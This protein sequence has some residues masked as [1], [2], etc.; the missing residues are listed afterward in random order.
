MP[1]SSPLSVKT[2]QEAIQKFSDEQTC[3]D[4]VAA[5][6]WPDG[7]T[8]PACGHKE[9]WYLKTQ[10]RWKCK[11]CHRQF[12]VKLGTIFED[13]PIGLDKWL[14][15]M[16]MI[17]NCKNGVSSYEIHRAIGVTQK[18]A[19]FM[20]HRLRLVM[21]QNNGC[22]KLGGGLK[23]VE[24]DETF[25]GGKARNMHKDV[26]ARRIHAK[27]GNSAVDKVLVMGM[28]ERGG[29]VRTE[30]IHNRFTDTLRQNVNKHVVSGSLLYT[31]ELQAYK[32]L[33]DEYSHMFV[34]HSES[35]VQGRVSTNGVENFWSLL[36]R[37]LGGT[38]V[39]VEPFHMFRYLDEQTWRYNNRGNKENPVNDGQRF[40]MALAQVT[41]KRLT[42]SALTGKEQVPA[43]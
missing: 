24:A 6:R 12:S 13:S 22:L 5:M 3:I 10:K 27:H 25:I 14:L 41:G 4:T 9:H 26:K 42:Y 37:T 20:L 43:E 7:V 30:I 28:L 29:H 31:D 2:L 40:Q 18:T 16:W 8:C 36:K 21:Q 34:D 38:Y 17:T 23:E 11:D 19:W 39:S 1:I 35:Y 32:G 33:G 15:A